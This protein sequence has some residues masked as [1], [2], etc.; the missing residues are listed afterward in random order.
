MNSN[1][2]NSFDQVRRPRPKSTIFEGFRHRRQASTDTH[3]LQ[4]PFDVPVSPI[5]PKIMAF[6]NYSNPGALAEL[7]YN[8]QT[9][10]PRLPQP[11]QRQDRGRSQS[12][13]KNSFGNFTIITA[14]GK[15]AKASKSRDPSPTKPKRPKS[16]TNL[17]GLL[18]PKTLR[19]LGRFNSEDDVNSSKDKENQTPEEPMAPPAQTPIYSQFASRPLLDQAQSSRR[20][21]DEPRPIIA[22]YSRLLDARSVEKQKSGLEQ[23]VWKHCL[24]CSANHISRLPLVARISDRPRLRTLVNAS[25]LGPSKW[26][27]LT[28]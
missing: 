27:L 7:Q 15:E 13:T 4:N 24:Q 16:A 11:Q 14:P 12:P 20:S 2:S 22:T 18:K 26:N 8:R 17:A 28:S 9:S 3:S 21:M 10:A 5:H 1:D 23:P 25:H 19:N 6:E